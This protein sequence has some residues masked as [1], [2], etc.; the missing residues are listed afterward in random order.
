[1]STFND[2]L[3]SQ[4]QSDITSSLIGWW[5]F[6]EGS[7]SFAFDNSGNNFSITTSNSP[8]WITGRVGLS[9]LHFISSSNQ[10]ALTINDTALTTLSGS[11][12][13]T[14]AAW[15]RTSTTPSQSMAGFV[16]TQG[17]ATDGTYDKGLGIQSNG[18]AGFYYFQS[19][20]AR[21][22]SGTS[23]LTD[24]NWHHIAVT[25][26]GQI[27]RMYVDGK[28]E[29]TQFAHSTFAFAS[30]FLVLSFAIGSGGGIGTWDRY[31]GDL[32]DI[33]FYSREL[34]AGDIQAL[35]SFSDTLSTGLLIYYKFDEGS[36][37]SSFDSSRNNRTGTLLNSA[38]WST[39][40]KVGPFAIN[41]NATL[42]SVSAS[43]VAVGSTWTIS[44][45]TLFPLPG[46]SFKTLTRNDSGVANGNHHVLVDPSNQLGCYLNSDGSGFHGSGYF[47]NTL[48]AGW[49]LV[50]AVGSGS[51]T[52]FYI[53][54][55]NVGTSNAQATDVLTTAGN[56]GGGGGQSWGIFD[57]FRLYGRPLSQTEITALYKRV[58]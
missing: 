28:L 12:P 19:P 43:A 30:T 6:E 39:A 10:F 21:I 18:K 51:K 26:N 38:T 49:H 37:T 13:L 40:S 45:W 2:V 52:V 48:T 35:Y 54:G 41:T 50:T 32:D 3:F 42:A 57:D 16:I 29:G 33:R 46:S 5:T 20:S 22:A 25:F 47:V 56:W 8:T 53:D 17:G 7:G 24:G 36:G 14:I 44:T 23:V 27:M 15:F 11:H 1:M 4:K 9:A 34:S 55:T 58:S 31:T